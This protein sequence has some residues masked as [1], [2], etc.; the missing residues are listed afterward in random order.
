M[1]TH[2]RHDQECAEDGCTRPAHHAD[3]CDA[4]YYTAA[5]E[6]KATCDLLDRLETEPFVMPDLSCPEMHLGADVARAAREVRELV[7]LYDGQ[8]TQPIDSIVIA[9]CAALE[10]L[11]YDVPAWGEGR[12]A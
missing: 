1:T 10:A 5:P 11:M 7:D 8:V 9:E 6:V 12:A 3:L 2:L 4:H